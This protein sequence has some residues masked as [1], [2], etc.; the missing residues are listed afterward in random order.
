MPWSSGWPSRV[1]RPDT[2]A[3]EPPQ[4]AVAAANAGDRIQ[5][6][7]GT[8]QLTAPLVLDK[9]LQIYCAG[10]MRNP[11]PLAGGRGAPETIIQ[12]D[13]AWPDGS[14]LVIDA[15]AEE[16]GQ[17][18]ERYGQLACRKEYMLFTAEDTGLVHCQTGALA[19]ATQRMFD[20]L[21][22]NL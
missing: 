6:A 2:D 13:L 15:E 18:K 3:C 19:V 11:R 10:G 20:W 21:D 17:A 8:Y 12:G 16:Y 4:P 9:P 1:T 22:E 5:I 14:V 7:G